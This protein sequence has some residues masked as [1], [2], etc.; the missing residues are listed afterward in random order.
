MRKRFYLFKRGAVYYLQDGITGK[1]QS[2]QTHSRTVAERLWHAHNE[3]TANPRMNLALARVYLSANDRKML[4]RTWQEVFDEFCSR[5]KAQTQV[6]RRRKTKHPAFDVLRGKPLVET[7]AE[8]LLAVLRTVGVMG[9]ACLRSMHN[10]ALGLGWLPWPILSPKLWPAHEFKAKRGLTWEEHEQILVAEKN[11]E[12]RLF[13][14]LLWETGASQTDAA[15]LR[16]ENIDWTNR[17]LIYR[18]IKTGTSACLA[19]GSRLEEIL[20]ALPSEGLLFPTVGASSVNARSAEFWRRCRLLGLRGVS[21]H[22]YRY[23]WAERAKT[24]GYPERFAQEALGHNSKAVHR[25]YAKRALVKIPSLDEFAKQT[26]PTK[27]VPFP[28]AKNPAEPVAVTARS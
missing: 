2:L 5:G 23:A 17:L 28:S 14:D 20:R 21:L 26:P 1:Q 24:C 7:T 9:S 25:A 27:I 13:Y 16:A 3:A 4:A 15:L 11:A 22:S 18:R 6:F 10:L 8:D 12:R 19:I